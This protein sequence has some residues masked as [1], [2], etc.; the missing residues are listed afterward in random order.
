MFSTLK[1]GVLG[2][3]ILEIGGF[4]KADRQVRKACLFNV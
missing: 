3:Q 1:G 4:R 2:A